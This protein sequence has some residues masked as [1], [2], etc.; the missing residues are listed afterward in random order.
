MINMVELRPDTIF[1]FKVQKIDYESNFLIQTKDRFSQLNYNQKKTIKKR[2]NEN[3]LLLTWL[4]LFP[5][6]AN[7]RISNSIIIILGVGKNS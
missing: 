3:C 5:T 2:N 6:L 4:E 7:N 1:Q